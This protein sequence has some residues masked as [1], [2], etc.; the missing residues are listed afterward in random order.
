MIGTL[1]Q[2]FQA[3]RAT[4]LYIITL[5]DPSA[6]AQQK[7]NLAKQVDTINTDLSAIADVMTDPDEKAAYQDLCDRMKIYDQVREQVVT[8]S[9]Q[10]PQ[11]ALDMFRTQAAP[12]AAEI[13]SVFHDLGHAG[14]PDTWIDSTGRDNIDRA[15]DGL[16]ESPIINR[17]PD[18]CIEMAKDMIRST[19]FPHTPHTYPANTPADAIRHYEYIRDAD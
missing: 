8:L 2:D 12:K 9:D 10:S 14:Y 4:V 19:R 17:Y 6:R 15:I 16:R 5:P 7:D 18:S 3:H 11:E 13:A 1:G